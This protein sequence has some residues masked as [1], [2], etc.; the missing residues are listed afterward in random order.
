[1]SKYRIHT[2]AQ[3][4]GLSAALIRAWESR[5]SL[6]VPARTPAGYRL[7]SDEDVAILNGAQR[8][9]RRGMAPMQVAKLTPEEIRGELV[10]DKDTCLLYTSPSPRD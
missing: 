9:L 3:M 5:Y 4:T 1:M 10:K 2:V 8:L 7:Y 6:V